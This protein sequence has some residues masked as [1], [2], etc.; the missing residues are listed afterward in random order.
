MLD[1]WCSSTLWFSTLSGLCLSRVLL[2]IYSCLPS[3]LQRPDLDLD[4]D[5]DRD[6]DLGSPWYKDDD[7]DDSDGGDGD[8][9]EDVGDDDH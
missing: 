1:A 8:D 4:I 9:G 6:L 5:I 7:G 3:S 2:V